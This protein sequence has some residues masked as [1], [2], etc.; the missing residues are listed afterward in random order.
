MQGKVSAGVL[1][2]YFV[3]IVKLTSLNPRTYCRPRSNGLL[4]C[5][6]DVFSNFLNY[7]C[8]IYGT[9]HNT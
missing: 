5:L 8:V 4:H 9:Q 6:P 2:S 1:S 3:Y 7:V